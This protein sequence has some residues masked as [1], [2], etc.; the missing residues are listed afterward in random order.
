MTKDNRLYGLE[1]QEKLKDFVENMEIIEC[2][3]YLFGA[4]SGSRILRS[5]YPKAIHSPFDVLVFIET[6]IALELL[7]PEN[8]LYRIKQA[9]RFT[10][11]KADTEAIFR[12]IFTHL[13]SMN[14]NTFDWSPTLIHTKEIGQ[15]S[16]D[17]AFD[18]DPE[19]SLSRIKN[20]NFIAN[21]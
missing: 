2:A 5:T 6:L 15:Q 8:I 10:F 4:L 13:N 14:K 1:V 7:I 11:H 3:A 21:N 12:G 17:E 19:E 18:E 16:T 20:I 9:S